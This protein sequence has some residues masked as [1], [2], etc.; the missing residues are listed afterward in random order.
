MLSISKPI[1]S[2]NS[3][4]A[5]GSGW[6]QIQTEATDG[7][8]AFALESVFECVC[9]SYCAILSWSVVYDTFH[10]AQCVVH[11][12]TL[13]SFAAQS[14]AASSL[15]RPPASS[16]NLL[17]D[18]CVMPAPHLKASESTCFRPFPHRNHAGWQ[19]LVA[20]LKGCVRQL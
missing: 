18:N 13:F 8:P 15:I 7:Q 10:A 6:Q 2:P 3:K 11:A 9:L 19:C 12:T 16:S 20:T 17:N 5:T 14:L 4:L 1:F